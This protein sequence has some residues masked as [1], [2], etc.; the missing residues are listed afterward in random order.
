MSAWG[1]AGVAG[2]PRTNTRA[3]DSSA[4]AAVALMLE[5]ADVAGEPGGPC[6][7]VGAYHIVVEVLEKVAAV[8]GRR[9]RASEIVLPWIAWVAASWVAAVV[10]VTSSSWA[11]VAAS[12]SAV[13]AVVAAF[14]V[15]ACPSAGC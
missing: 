2:Q 10:A 5:A 6:K 15:A 8:S 4:L 9:R 7:A 14:S 13:V 1:R 12:S 3:V 11:A